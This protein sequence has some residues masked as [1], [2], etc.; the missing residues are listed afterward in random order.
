MTTQ[1]VLEALA[2]EHERLLNAIDALGVGAATVP[3]TQE[4]W[5]V[6]DV[7][8]H[9]IHY[10]GQLA[11]AAGAALVPPAYVIEEMQ[12]RERAGVAERPTGDEWNALAVAHYSDLPL[13][14]VRGEFDSIVDAL[15]T[16]LQLRSDEQMNAT[17]AIPWA[18]PLPLWQH[19]GGDAFLHWA[20]HSEAIERAAASA[21]TP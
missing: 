14:R 20:I 15:V 11:S 17:D 19:V 3:V 10:A 5:T 13:E 12:R 6:K 2:R 1:E 8:A 4:G 16:R 7:L 21:A 18:G 9:L